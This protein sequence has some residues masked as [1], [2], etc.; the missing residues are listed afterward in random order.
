MKEPRSGVSPTGVLFYTG[1]AI[2]VEG[3]IVE[4]I[5][6]FIMAGRWRAIGLTALFALLGVYFIPV[7][8]ISGAILGLITLRRGPW[9]GITVIVSAGLISWLIFSV[10]P[11]KP[12]FPF[13][14]SYALW[15]PVLLGAAVLR[16]TLSQGMMLMAVGGW[17]ILYVSAMHL[18]TGDV[19][20]FWKGWLELAVANVKGATVYGFEEEGT[21][22]LINSLVALLYGV[23]TVT[24]L[25]LARWWQAILYHPGGFAAEFRRLQLPRGLIA[26]AV[27]IVWLAG[28]WD[29]IL[30]VDLMVAA[31]T[32]YL[33][34]GLA[35][36]HFLVVR[37]SGS[38]F[39]LVP[40]YGLLLMLPQFSL[41][42]V[43][44]LGAVDSLADFRGLRAEGSD[45]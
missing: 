21:L 36:V 35:V 10:L 16:R 37:F 24:A 1:T 41:M 40:V 11:P 38:W 33:F 3:N 2:N 22:R 45:S 26:V 9:E 29:K 44:F 4:E 18:I 14:L 8:I 13:P 32:M 12:G 27:G 43:A 30:M 39:W 7:S 31:M 15:P 17:L 5:A 42:A 34:Q 6:R 25:L 20:A 28:T 19:V 23:G